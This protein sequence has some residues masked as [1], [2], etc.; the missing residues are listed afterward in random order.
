M[1]P[2][3]PQD[4]TPIS[5][6]PAGLLPQLDKIILNLILGSLALLY[7]GKSSRITVGVFVAITFLA[8][9]RG[10]IEHRSGLPGRARRRRPR[11]LCR[12]ARSRHRELHARPRGR[13]FREAR[14]RGFPERGEERGKR[15][16]DLLHEWNPLRRILGER[17]SFHRSASRAGV[18]VGNITR[19]TIEATSRKHR[20][21]RLGL[22]SL[23]PETT[24]P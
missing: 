6:G 14:S 19:L 8:V 18:P 3:P 7:W 20:R 4:H 23:R 16:A 2:D 13:D 21:P 24:L 11:R 22:G 15:H 1:T 12:V 10:V 5:A 17:R 9:A